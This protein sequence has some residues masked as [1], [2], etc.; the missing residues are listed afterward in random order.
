LKAL[1]FIDYGLGMAGFIFKNLWFYANGMTVRELFVLAVIGGT[2]SALCNN[3]LSVRS[4]N[5][6]RRYPYLVVALVSQAAAYLLGAWLPGFVTF[7]V[8]TFLWTW[9]SSET[10][11]TLVAYNLIA[12]SKDPTIPPEKDSLSVEYSKY[13]V[14]GSVGFAIAAPLVGL[15]IDAVNRGA[16]LDPVNGLVGYQVLFTICGVSYLVL[17]AVMTYFLRVYIRE[18]EKLE[19]PNRLSRERGEGRVGLRSL[20]RNAFFLGIVVPQGL[21]T[22]AY[23]VGASVIEVFFTSLGA[24]LVFIGLRP[25]IWALIEVPIF[26]L[27]AWLT[28]RYGH[29]V[30]LF[31]AYQ[32]FTIRLVV[33][34]FIMTPELIWLDLV[35]S[36]LNTFGMT[37]P[38]ITSAFQERFPEQRSLAFSVMTT[39]NGLCGLT[40][41][42]IGI[43]ISSLVADEGTIFNLLFATAL[44]IVL[45]LSVLLVWINRR[46]K[47][48]HAPGDQ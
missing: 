17:T 14:F 24:N 15:G 42:L 7:V 1:S 6:N 3:L 8:Y 29:V 27:S 20:L 22:M 4:D 37:W 34:Y 10:Y 13:R 39:I 30:V 31:I 21:Y 19:N 12:M 32:F 35:L 25:F 41:G 9:V 2:V 33:Y 26:F 47:K 43:L 46:A 40:G 44:A 48:M 16:G 11:R 28:K 45:C 36:L 5:S 18:E 38:A 23:S